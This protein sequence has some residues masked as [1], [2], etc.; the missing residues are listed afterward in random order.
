MCC[1]E[2]V[3]RRGTGKRELNDLKK[4]KIAVELKAGNLQEF[5][6]NMLELPMIWWRSGKRARG[7]GREPAK[8]GKA[9]ALGVRTVSI[10]FC[11]PFPL[12]L[13][14][15]RAAF[16]A[17]E[18]LRSFLNIASTP[19][20]DVRYSANCQEADPHSMTRTTKETIA[21]TME[22]IFR[23]RLFRTPKALTERATRRPRKKICTL[24]PNY[25]KHSQPHQ[26]HMP[27]NTALPQR[28]ISVPSSVQFQIPR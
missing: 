28:H 4:P 1:Y 7:V 10:C 13:E 12:A 20:I 19:R 17:S 15:D 3:G 24:Q 25:A 23:V 22:V 26:N 5:G 16:H 11:H 8:Q 14:N 21:K 18:H 27:V 6:Y 2:Q 9:T